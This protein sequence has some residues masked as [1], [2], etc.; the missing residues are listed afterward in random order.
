MTKDDSD[1]EKLMRAG[2]T[3]FLMLALL[4]QG[5]AAPRAGDTPID[6]QATPTPV[7]T[8]SLGQAFLQRYYNQLM[9]FKDEAAFRFYGFGVGGPYHSWLTS[10]DA[11]YE[12]NEFALMEGVAIN[13]LRQLGMA[14]MRSNGVENSDTRQMAR[15]VKTAI[16]GEG[17]D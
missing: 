5:C 14:Y 1:E 11:K 7:P 8:L 3:C 13:Y 2:A 15:E 12:H 4:F 10:V 6:R 9:G 16:A 17:W